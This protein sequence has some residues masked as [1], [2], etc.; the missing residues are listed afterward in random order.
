MNQ[1]SFLRAQDGTEA[2]VLPEGVGPTLRRLREARR[3][4]PADVS[5][6]L[7]FSQRQLA[8][9]EN[10][11]WDK[12]PGGMSLRGF[13]KNYARYLD[14]DVDAM[15]AMLDNQLGLPRSPF[16]AVRP[17]A[18]L[19]PAD[20]AP[21]DDATR[22]PWG[23]FVVILALILAAVFYAFDRGWIPDSWLAFDWLQ[24]FRQ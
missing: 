10:E 19:Q 21:A 5:L 15:L 3:L 6:R 7:K 22:R 1:E 9:L 8:A 23:W 17:S 13:V 16:A 11:E 14:A 12:L 24:S 2:A 4:T 18:A 20:M